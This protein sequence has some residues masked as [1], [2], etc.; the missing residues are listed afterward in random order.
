MLLNQRIY[1]M[2]FSMPSAQTCLVFQGIPVHSIFDQQGAYI[3]AAELPI[4]KMIGATGMLV[5]WKYKTIQ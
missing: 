5:Q 2:A 4:Q 1:H 3:I